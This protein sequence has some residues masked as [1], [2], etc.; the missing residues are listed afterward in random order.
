MSLCRIKAQT[1]ASKLPDCW[2]NSKP[3][4]CRNGRQLT[5]VLIYNQAGLTLL[6][7]NAMH[8]LRSALSAAGSGA[9]V[10]GWQDDVPHTVDSS[11]PPKLSATFQ[12][13]QQ[14]QVPAARTDGN[15]V[16]PDDTRLSELYADYAVHTPDAQYINAICMYTDGS[17]GDASITGG[18][19]ING[20]HSQAFK[21]EGHNPELNTALRAELAAISR[22]VEQLDA[23]TPSAYPRR[24]SYVLTDSLSSIFLINKGLHNPDGLKS[25]KHRDLVFK[26]VQQL[27]SSPLKV[28]VAKVRAHTGVNGNEAADRL[29]QE[30][31]QGHVTAPAFNTLG[32]AGRG[33]HW[34]HYREMPQDA[35]LRNAADLKDHLVALVQST[36]AQ[37]VLQNPK[38]HSVLHKVSR[39]LTANGGIAAQ[40]ASHLWTS[41][42]L[43]PFERSLAAQFW[44]NRLWTLARQRKC[45]GATAVPDATCPFCH[46]AEETTDHVAN[47]C[48][49]PQVISLVKRRH[50]EAVANILFSV[51]EGKPKDCTITCD[52]RTVSEARRA[53]GVHPGAKL[54]AEVLPHAQQH[55]YPDLC[56]INVKPIAGRAGRGIS[57]AEKRQAWVR[58]VELK[59]A[60]DL[61]LHGRVR[62]DAI[63]QHAALR[64]A[65]LAVGWGTVTIHPVVI[66]NAGTITAE[67]LN[68]FVSLG[69]SPASTLKLAKRLAIAS[70]KHSAEIKRARLSH[71]A[72]PQGAA[73]APAADPSASAGAAQPRAPTATDTAVAGIPLQPSP[74]P[75]A[76][77]EASPTCPG[78]AVVPATQANAVRTHSREVSR[79]TMPDPDAWQTV[80][81]PSCMK[82]ASQSDATLHDTQTLGCPRPDRA[83]KRSR[84]F[85]AILAALQEDEPDD[86]L[87][88]PA[89]KRGQKRCRQHDMQPVTPALPAGSPPES[90]SAGRPASERD[91]AS[92]LLLPCPK[93]DL[94]PANSGLAR[95]Q[96]TVTG[97]TLT[98]AMASR[99]ESIAR[100]V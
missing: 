68:A 7:R 74:S 78:P 73:Q 51:L 15:A 1:I 33:L 75:S 50:D 27:L 3:L 2:L 54:P 28:R 100:R 6:N 16:L 83:C 88:R 69:I 58:I 24:R 26:I 93:T 23:T 67:T 45:L 53:A 97:P 90:S 84:G 4:P 10:V 62:E 20:G 72:G 76:S 14:P 87:P 37:H 85:Y 22:G 71:A 57:S 81:R 42:K 70:I 64:N 17:K 18:V 65:L 47:Q 48:N 35:G 19:Y 61:E 44:T 82:R 41:G 29:A 8:G 39:L 63:A 25:H 36:R 92:A 21:L 30:A 43:T 96:N 60:P 49:L 38:Q 86:S 9:E 91:E 59:Y 12:A 94:S 52:A 80:I 77:G 79:S 31:Q 46:Q 13:A 5:I 95:L 32:D 40:I 98:A 99:P 34:I 89:A 55:S 11:R 56:L 66:G